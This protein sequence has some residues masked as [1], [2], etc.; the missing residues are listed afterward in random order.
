MTKDY[1][2]FPGCSL[3]GTAREFSE[4]LEAV[5]K[6]LGYRLEE[7]PDWNCCGATS[8]HALAPAA[9]L[10]LGM[11]NLSQAAAS[12]RPLVVPCASCY[13]NLR[14]AR[15]AARE[16]DPHMPPAPAGADLETIATVEVVHPLE[17]LTSDEALSQVRARVK[18]PLEGMKV[19]T[20]YGCLL[21]RPP[22]AVKFDD[23]ENP[24][25]MDMLVEA[26]GAK[27]VDWSWKTDCCGGN[28]ALGATDITVT[29]VSR[30]IAA[31]EE[32]GANAIVVA[33]PLCHA[34][35]DMRQFEASRKLRRKVEMPVF[36]FSELMALAYDLPRTEKWLKKHITTVFPLVDSILGGMDD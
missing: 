35:L 23:T 36:Y 7:L 3:R 27:S 18:T 10:A 11:R 28:L 8:G 9:A 15:L 21:S 17:V 26:L 4:S 13:A 33:C 24:V 22:A 29:L 2:Y 20:Y 12:Q 30:I 6:H 32:A 14:S 1:G 34:N 31:A 19:A 16:G 5:M 25:R